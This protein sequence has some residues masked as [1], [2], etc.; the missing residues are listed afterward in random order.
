MLFG[1]QSTGLTHIKSDVDIAVLADH[2]LNPYEI[3][4]C[5]YAF[6]IALQRPDIEIVDLQHTS[7]LLMKAVAHGTVLFESAPHLFSQFQMYAFKRFV[8]AK[9]LYALRRTSLKQFASAA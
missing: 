2:P 5:A 6:S 7:P 1:S 4:E 8:E 3:A 9:P